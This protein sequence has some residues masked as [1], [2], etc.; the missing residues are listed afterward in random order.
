MR[1]DPATPLTHLPPLTHLLL[2]SRCNKSPLTRLSSSFFQLYVTSFGC[3]WTLWV[4]LYVAHADYAAKHGHRNSTLATVEHPT[5]SQSVSGFVILVS[6][7]NLLAAK[8]VGGSAYSERRS[9]ADS[10]GCLPLVFL[11]HVVSR[12]P[13]GDAR[14]PS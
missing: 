4:A 10:L 8:G 12:P 7:V 3:Y 11:S 5:S 6:L 13:T 1:G 2:D 14:L 9:R